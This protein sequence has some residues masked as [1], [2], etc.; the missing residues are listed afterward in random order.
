MT[1]DAKQEA[2]RGYCRK[3]EALSVDPYAPDLPADDPRHDEVAAIISEYKAATSPK[4]ALPP[5]WEGHEPIQPVDTLLALAEWLAFQ[6]R[7]V[8]GWELAGD[9][10]RPSALKDA[11]R[12]LRNAFRVLDWLGVEG[13]P[14]RPLPTDNLE[15]AKKQLDDL[16]RWIRDKHKSGWQP[17]PKMAKP[18]PAPTAKKHPKRGEIPDDYEANIRIKK[19]LESHPKATIRDVAAEVGLSTGKVAQLDAWKRAMAE[20][21]AAKPRP[22]K[23]ERPLTDKM[24]AA[25][26][27]NDDPAAKVM[28]DE[29]IWQWLLET[30]KPKEKAELH[31]KNAEERA[32]LI[33]LVREQ[34]QK[35][36]ADPG[37]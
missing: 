4:L 27:Q 29:A 11:S 33:E 21:K 37:D 13:R 8:K 30:A 18:A 22:K 19:Y 20:R 34:Y 28:Q 10:A 26:G 15:A 2:W 3:L 24:L 1:D 14:E 12:A 7:L 36:H 9:K 6:W 16:E 31:M 17:T 5:N 35:D 25:K 23:A 32:T